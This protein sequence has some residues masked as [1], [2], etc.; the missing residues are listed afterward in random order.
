M[1]D[2]VIEMVTRAT[3]EMRVLLGEL[4]DV[5]SAGYPP[6]QRHGLKIDAL[7]QPHIRFFVAQ[8]DGTA[9]G[10]GGVAF[11]PISPS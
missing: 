3:D 8:L 6:E 9:V 1:S 7:F 2:I 11:F 4:D 10:C 5:L